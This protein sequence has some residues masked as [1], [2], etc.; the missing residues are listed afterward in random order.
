MLQ[1]TGPYRRRSYHE[2]AVRH[3][4]RDAGE[5]LGFRH[6]FARADRRFRLAKRRLVWRHHAQPRESE[7]AHR[8]RRCSDVQRVA[9]R[10]QHHAEASEFCGSQ[11]RAPFYRTPRRGQ[12]RNLRERR[13]QPLRWPRIA[14]SIGGSPAALGKL[15]QR[16]ICT[17]DG[18]PSDVEEAWS[19]LLGCFPR[20]RRRMNWEYPRRTIWQHP[21]TFTIR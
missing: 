11:Q 13:L 1:V 19:S 20:H 10:D 14:R 16:I 8:P 9:C 4:L 18:G 17:G 3:G 5:L 12:R 21:R 2:R 15:S 7:I 6:H